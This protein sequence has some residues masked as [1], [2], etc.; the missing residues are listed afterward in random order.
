MSTARP[1]LFVYGTLRSGGAHEMARF[2]RANSEFLGAAELPGAALYIVGQHPGVVRT[3]KAK[4][5]VKGELFELNDESVLARLDRYEDCDLE[6]P[7][8]SE[9]LR[10]QRLVRLGK[11]RKVRA[12]VYEYNRSVDGLA[13]LANGVYRP[14]R[15]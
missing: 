7:D 3:T 1:K 2:L 6:S 14:H 4:S 11:S 9:Y 12:W 5:T 10:R 8:D 13:P 15:D